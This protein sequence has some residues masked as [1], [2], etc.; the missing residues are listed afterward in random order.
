MS[1][2]VETVFVRV[3][4]SDG[5]DREWRP[6][7]GLGTKA[8]MWARTTVA[9]ATC[10]PVCRSSLVTS[11]ARSL[12]AICYTFVLTTACCVDFFGG[13]ELLTTDLVHVQHGS[14]PS[15][16][17]PVDEGICGTYRTMFLFKKLENVSCEYDG[18][19]GWNSTLRAAWYIRH[20]RWTCFFYIS[21]IILQSMVF[22]S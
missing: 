14:S 3:L 19:N 6:Q 17:L 2:K 8:N 1:H 22:V 21:F 12:L 16:S 18:L 11:S 20:V 9:N 4:S 5:C 10:E 13:W 7:T 15:C